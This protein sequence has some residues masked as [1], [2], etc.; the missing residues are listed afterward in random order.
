MWVLLIMGDFITAAILALAT[1]SIAI[2]MSKTAIFHAYRVR[3]ALTHPMLGRL[4][5]CHFCTSHW[6]AGA[7]ML[8][9]Q[10]RLITGS[11]FIVDLAVSYFA[12]V[13]T[14]AVVAG[15]VLYLTPMSGHSDD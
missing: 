1:A 14:A 10:P 15:W 2:A 12:I 3:M 8:I 13:M 11:W 4:A 5:G 6:A 9:Y 7:L